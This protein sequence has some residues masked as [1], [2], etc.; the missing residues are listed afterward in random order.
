MRANGLGLDVFF[1]FFY[2]IRC[3]EVNF[4]DLDP[5]WISKYTKKFLRDLLDKHIE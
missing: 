3:F 5:E 4:I 1:F 2:S